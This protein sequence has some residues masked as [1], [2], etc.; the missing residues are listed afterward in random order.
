MQ[1]ATDLDLKGVKRNSEHSWIRTLM[2]NY[3][4]FKKMQGLQKKLSLEIQRGDSRAGRGPNCSFCFAAKAAGKLLWQRLIQS[5]TEITA[6][7]LTASGGSPTIGYL[8]KMDHKDKGSWNALSDA[9]KPTLR[10]Y[11]F[12]EH[13]DRWKFS[14]FKSELYKN[15]MWKRDHF[16]QPSVWDGKS[17]L[18]CF[19]ER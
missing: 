15:E 18:S 19:Q 3:M 17:I 10:Y 6:W 2:L 16:Y 13:H 4:T 14:K 9:Q 11:P 5:L 1:L 7:M 12:A 8:K